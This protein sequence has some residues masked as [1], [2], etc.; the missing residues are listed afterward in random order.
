MVKRARVHSKTT[1][2]MRIGLKQ[3]NLDKGHDWL[4]DVTHPTSESYGKF[5]SSEEVIKAFQPS[6]E[7]V[8][9]VR[10]WL[11]SGGIQDARI[12]HSDNKAWLAFDATADEAEQLLHTTFHHYQH[13]STGATYMATDEYHVPRSLQQH[14]DYITPGVKGVKV[15]AGLKKRAHKNAL[16]GGVAPMRGPAPISPANSSSLATCDIAVTP[17]CIRALYGFSAPDPKAEVC[18]TNAIGVFEEG[19]TYAQ[20]D[21]DSF[22]TNFTPGK[23]NIPNGTHP[24]LDAVDGATAPV[25]VAEA[26]GESDLDFELIYPIV[27]PQ[28][29]TLYQTDDA[30]YAGGTSNATGI[31]NTFL[32]AID[33]SYCKY[34]AFGECGNDPNL[35]PVYPDTTEGG[36]K[37]KLQCGVFKPTNVISISYGEQEQDLPAYYQQRQCNEYLKLGL[38]GVSIFVASGD[39][40]VAGIP[41]DG[42]ANGCLRNGTVFSPT[43]PNSCP[44]LTNV[45]ATKIYPGKTVFDPESAAN[46]LPGQPHRSAYSSGGGFSNLFPIPDYQKKAVSTY[47]TKHNPKYPYYYDGK[48]NSSTNGLYNRN[49]RGIPDVAAVGDNI[50]VYVGGNFTL[51]GGTSASAPIFAGLVNRIVEE[52][53]RQGKGPVGFI[54]PVLY[55]N[56]WVL[57]DIKNGSNPGCGTNGFD[58]VEGWDPVTGLGTPNYPKML[59]L[60]LS[61][62]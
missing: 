61:L 55:E 48:Y 62:P 59:D 16:S 38:Q 9:A 32:D 42:S 20:E 26:G 41:G 29:V 43:Q 53:I 24:T 31:F 22:F 25:P 57:N 28:K 60:F 21:L 58:A 46:D 36:Y 5:W 35:D 10:S 19:D 33:G 23:Y 45:G 2:P 8:E 11:V 37:G 3:N 54:N 15:G 14:I 30:Y 49:G 40:G 50:A 56:P 44:Y 34:C 17:A 12:T 18:P 27:Y 1:L 6:D 39:S 13:G 4:M 51:E 7:T 52:R 47:F